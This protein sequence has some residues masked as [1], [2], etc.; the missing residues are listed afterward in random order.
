MVPATALVPLFVGLGETGAFIA[1]LV[2]TTVINTAIA[3]VL[4]KLLAPSIGSGRDT[5]GLQTTVKNNIS[6]RT[7]IYGEALVGGTL[8]EINTGGDSNKFLDM[9]IVLATHP[10]EDVLGVFVADQYIDIHGDNYN[11]N[12]LDPAYNVKDGG[13]FGSTDSGD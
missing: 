4:G 8:I 10:V 2:A 6:P 1:S 11:N 12:A 9:I 7:V 13:K 5:R 3:S